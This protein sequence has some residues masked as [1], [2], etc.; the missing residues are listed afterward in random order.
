MLDRLL[1]TL[2]VI[3]PQ[4]PAPLAPPAPRV[5]T[6]SLFDARTGRL[7]PTAAALLA[8]DLYDGRATYRWLLLR[9]VLFVTGAS[10]PYFQ[11]ARSLTLEDRAAV[12][13]G[14]ISLSLA[15][16]CAPRISIV[17]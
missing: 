3:P 8:A 10:L 1:D 17:T 2:E 12:E 5:I 11:A 4:A 7:S 13:A 15:Q 16:R 14:D 6:G 9:H